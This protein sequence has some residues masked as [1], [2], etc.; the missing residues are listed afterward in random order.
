MIALLKMGA[1]LALCLVMATVL[2]K[3]TISALELEKRNALTGAKRL[4]F[5]LI[6]TDWVGV[7]WLSM[8]VLSRLS[9]L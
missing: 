6:I 3:F 7:A 1:L 2:L 9:S 5:A 8:L 4:V